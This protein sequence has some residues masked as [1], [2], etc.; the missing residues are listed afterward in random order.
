MANEEHIHILKQGAEVW[1]KWRTGNP[2]VVPDLSSAQ[3]SGVNFSALAP[4]TFRPVYFPRYCN[5]QNVD[6]EF[7]TLHAATFRLA[8]LKGASFDTDRS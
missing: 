3:L 8:D 6:F 2:N 7:A 1:N 4:A 5:F